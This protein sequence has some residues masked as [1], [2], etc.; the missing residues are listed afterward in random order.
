MMN[1]MNMYNDLRIVLKIWILGANIFYYKNI[2]LKIHVSWWNTWIIFIAFINVV[3]DT[4]YLSVV[5][6]DWL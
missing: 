4:K 3:I 1:N 2:C 5:T 6:Y